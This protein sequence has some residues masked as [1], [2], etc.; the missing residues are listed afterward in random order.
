MRS[1]IALAGAAIAALSSA[2]ACATSTKQFTTSGGVSYTYEYSPA[3]D[4]NGTSKPTFLFFHGFPSTR[5]DWAPQLAALEKAG[6]GVLAPDLLG[7]G[8][9]DKPD[10]NNLSAYRWSVVS[11]H[12]AELLDAE[13]LGQ[14]IGVGHDWGATAMARAYNY[15]PD[16]FSKLV[17]MSVGYVHPTGFIDI[18]AINAQTLAATGLAQCGYWYFFNHFTATDLISNHLE[19]FY[20]AVYA[21]NSTT[22][23]RDVGHIGAARARLEANRTIP[24]APWDTE[25]HKQDWLSQFSKP[26]AVAPSL[27]PY[28]RALTGTD[29]PDDN[30]VPEV[31]KLLN[32]PVTIIGGS[33]D[34]ITPG[35]VMRVVTEPFAMRGLEEY[36]LQGGHWLGWENADEVNAILSKAGGD[37]AR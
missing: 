13:G 21:A 15:H 23:N 11:D 28:R 27:N 36:Q 9:S 31:N 17:F 3:T 10:P 8:E 4:Y 26:G 18:D 24:L 5:R 30:A 32:V 25:A 7:F 16:R 35:A 12:M 14:V 6:F 34:T 19:S 37:I 29:V 1:S 22:Q 2:L 20:S 33:L